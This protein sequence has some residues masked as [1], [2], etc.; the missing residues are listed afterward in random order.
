MI[1]SI[2]CSSE[3]LGSVSTSYLYQLTTVCNSSLRGSMP[4]SKGTCPH[5]AFTYTDTQGVSLCVY[6]CVSV[7]GE[8]AK[9]G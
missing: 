4:S 5:I 7:A 9:S 3:D 2:C 8:M 6:K 1:K